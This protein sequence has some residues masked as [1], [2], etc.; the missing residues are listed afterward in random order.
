MKNWTHRHKEVI[1]SFLKY[2]NDKTDNFI[3]KGGTALMT[4][5]KLDRFSEDIDFDGKGQN[6][7]NYVSEYCGSK[8]FSYRVAKDTDTVKRYFI[9]YGND[10][11]PLKIEISYR[12]KIIDESDIAKI[13]G[14]IVYTIS[15]LSIMKAWAY[16]SRDR[17]RDLYDLTFI[18][19]NYFEQLPKEVIFMIRNAV[20]HKGIGQFDYIKRTQPD[21]L[22]DYDA[23]E[24][25][26]LQMYNN[27]GLLLGENE[28]HTFNTQ[29]YDVSVDDEIEDGIEP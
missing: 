15:A 20:E 21:E 10:K 23:L 3:L 16:S 22:I 5:Y 28:R 1:L 13:N 18:C 19:G 14:I 9:N 12:K 11:K 29:N 6:V 2:I 25:K 8:N 7:E 24:Y 26:F 17:V 27:L 4:C